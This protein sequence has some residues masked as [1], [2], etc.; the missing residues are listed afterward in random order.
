MTTNYIQPGKVL[1]TIAA[2][3]VNSGAVLIAGQRGS[4]VIWR[5]LLYFFFAVALAIILKGGY[6]LKAVTTC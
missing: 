3:D 6:S 2:A 5:G 4:K 1:D